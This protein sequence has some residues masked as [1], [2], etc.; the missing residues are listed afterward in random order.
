MAVNIRGFTHLLVSFLLELDQVL[1]GKSGENPRVLPT[2]G[3]E[4]VSFELQQSIKCLP[5]GETI[6]L[7]PNKLGLIKT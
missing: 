6:S 2:E 4:T 3:E 7:E 1:I 5:S